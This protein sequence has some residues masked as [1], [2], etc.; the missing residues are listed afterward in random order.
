MKDANDKL[1]PI[2]EKPASKDGNGHGNGN[3]SNSDESNHDD[4]PGR[5]AQILGMTEAEM[6]NHEFFPSGTVE[7]VQELE[8]QP[9]R[10]FGKGYESFPEGENYPFQLIRS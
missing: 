5:T 3:G 2:V 6:A 10:G 4:S 8:V 7:P 1:A 9:T